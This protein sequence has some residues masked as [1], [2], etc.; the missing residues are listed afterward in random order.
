MTDQKS[1]PA[2]QADPPGQAKGGSGLIGWVALIVLAFV[3]YQLYLGLTFKKVGV[4]GLFEMEFNPPAPAPAAPAEIDVSRDY[5]VGRWR[6]NQSTGALSGETVTEY[7]DDGT[8]ESAS[9]RFVG[10]EGQR[11]QFGGY[12]EF[13]KLSANRFKLFL[14][15]HNGGT[16]SGTF[17]ALDKNRV[18]NIDQNYI[19][20]RVE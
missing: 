19:A 3:G 6:A 5:F 16:W 14:E 17:K 2:G 7:F 10:A 9:S 1:D 4:P 8:F 18:H 15:D 13:E 11:Q 12:W 20:E